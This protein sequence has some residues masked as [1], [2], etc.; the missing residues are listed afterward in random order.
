MSL[1]STNEETIGNRV[2]DSISSTHEPSA[3]LLLIYRYRQF[4]PLNTKSYGLHKAYVAAGD[5]RIVWSW[6]KSIREPLCARC[7]MVVLWIHNLVCY[8]SPF[9]LE[10]YMVLQK[11]PVELKRYLVIFSLS[12]FSYL[13]TMLIMAKPF[14][15]S[16]RCFFVI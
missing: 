9:V 4:R 5:T 11:G 1:D 7:L 14:L 3:F 12:L 13:Q 10:L 15:K 2:W 6:R 8:F 16:M